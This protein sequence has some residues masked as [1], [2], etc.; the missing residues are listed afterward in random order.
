M[1]KRYRD[2]PSTSCLHM[3][4]IPHDQYSLPKDTF[5]TLDESKLI[6]HT[7][8]LWFPFSTLGSNN[9]L[10]KWNLKILWKLHMM[11]KKN[12]DEYLKYWTCFPLTLVLNHRIT[13]EIPCRYIQF[14]FIKNNVFGQY[15]PILL[16]YFCY[17]LGEL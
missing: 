16:N 15:R 12:F 10:F 7:Q 3:H 5:V 2:F 13:S 11:I 9:T 14:K 6:Y 17:W 8:V 1:S 4:G